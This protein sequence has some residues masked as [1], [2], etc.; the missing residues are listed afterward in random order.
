MS[1]GPKQRK[2]LS[3]KKKLKS[4]LI[5]AHK[6]SQKTVNDAFFRGL[7]KAEELNSPITKNALKALVI[8]RGFALPVEGVVRDAVGIVNAQVDYLKNKKKRKKNEKERKRKITKK[9]VSKRL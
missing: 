2:K 6:K 7:A 1:T 5:Q 3:L 8:A 4:D 9:I